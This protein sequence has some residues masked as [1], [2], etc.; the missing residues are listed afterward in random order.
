MTITINIAN[1]FSDA[2]GARYRKDGPFS[3]EQFFS[4][5]LDKQFE[6]VRNNKSKLIIELDGTWGYA[7]SFLSEAF[8]LLSDKYG[9]EEVFEIIVLTSDE[10]PELIEYIEKIIKNP[11][12]K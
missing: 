4:D 3:G 9:S 10:D 5:F 7:T 11:R 6:D 1:D 2:P 12:V 8:G